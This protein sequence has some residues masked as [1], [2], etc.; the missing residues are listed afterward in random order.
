MHWLIDLSYTASAAEREAAFGWL[1][2]QYMP[3]GLLGLAL[4]ALFAAIMSTV[5]S[6]MNLGAQVILNDV[7]KRF[8]RPKAEL[9]EYMMVS[10]V[11]M[12][13]I[14]TAGIVVAMLADSVIAFAVLML[15]FSSAELPANWAQW[16]W[17][18]FNGAARMAASFGGVIFFLINRFLIF[19]PMVEAGTMSGSTAAYMVVLASMGATTLLWVSVAL[20]TKPDD[21]ETL[22]A[23]Y[24]EARPIG[25][26][27]P[28]ARKANLQHE[29]KGKSILSGL[30]IAIAGL[31]ALCS[32]T[33]VL[34]ALYLGQ[35]SLAFFAALVA[36][37]SGTL[38]FF[39][40]Q[41]FI[42]TL[43]RDYQIDA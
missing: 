40:Y 7:Y 4:L 37:F 25:F 35:L 27:G 30:G 36:A 17:W 29:Q 43:E 24:K 14:L 3:P 34:Y 39:T 23:F 11:A 32:L 21:E 15:Q 20:L 2:G 13:A 6:N 31:I 18:R 33:I 19:D 28:I 1:L 41:R 22:V 9:S 38:F 12:I 26:W 5:D 16:W 42:S 8:F 10:R